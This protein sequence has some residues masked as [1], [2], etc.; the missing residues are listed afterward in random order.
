MAGNETTTTN[1][2]TTDNTQTQQN[3]PLS[4]SWGQR[5]GLAGA[6]AGGIIEAL[7]RTLGIDPGRF[8]MPGGGGGN[9]PS[10][11]GDD[12]VD[13]LNDQQRDE[14]K[15]LLEKSE[16]TEDDNKKIREL[17]GLGGDNPDANRLRELNELLQQNKPVAQMSEQDRE[18]LFNLAKSH[19]PD[20]KQAEFRTQTLGLPAQPPA[21]TPQQQP[22]PATTPQTQD[23]TPQPPA[24][25]P[26]QQ[27]APAA[28]N[29]ANPAATP[30]TPGV[31]NSA[32]TGSNSDSQPVR[33]QELEA[34]TVNPRR[35]ND[36]R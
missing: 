1:T 32:T 6:I 9:T 27:P 7:L 4:Q 11:T 3:V 17:L 12:A 21:T 2:P 28:D 31:N 30:G 22:A 23:Q 36:G 33:F 13:K 26:Q 5:F 25:T 14:L 10:T 18:R 20:D 34:R 29:A 16:R 19:I 35:Q 15:K 24:T 8:N